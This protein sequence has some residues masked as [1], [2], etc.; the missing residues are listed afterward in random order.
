ML[1]PDHDSDESGV[2][3]ILFRGIEMLLFEVVLTMMW[4]SG[5]RLRFT[6][7]GLTRGGQEQV[8]VDALGPKRVG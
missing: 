7:V 5:T 1:R 6:H 3:L 8:Q 4:R 2:G